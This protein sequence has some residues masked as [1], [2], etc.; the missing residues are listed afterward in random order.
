MRPRDL[1]HD[2]GVDP[3]V[4]VGQEVAQT[5]DLGPRDLR[6][7]GASVVPEVSGRLADDDEVVENSIPR[8]DL[9][10]LARARKVGPYAVYGFDDVAQT[11]LFAAAPSSQRG[12]ASVSA[13][14]STSGRK[15]S[16]DATSMRKP[17]SWDS[18]TPR[19]RTV[20]S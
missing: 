14:S 15:V 16:G 5:D 10:R 19:P 17:K 18:S 3:E 11:R 4:L 8:R 6:C 12:T 20:M 1:A 13:C 9:E 7:P 2:L